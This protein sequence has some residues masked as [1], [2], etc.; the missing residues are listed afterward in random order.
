MG[1]GGG[2]TG[3]S[4]QNVQMINWMKSNGY[5]RGSRNIPFN[6]YA[7]TQE[8]GSELIYRTSDGAVL[9]PL[10]KGDK[11]FTN[12]MSERLWELAKGDFA[13]IQPNL[14]PGSVTPAKSEVN[15]NVTIQFG[16]INLPNVTNY[17]EFRSGLIKDGKFQKAVQSMTLGN[18]LGKNSLNKLRNL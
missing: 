14:I 17:E 9:T 3:S 18:A 1:F 8:K 6:Q 13:P 5:Y 16:D 12:E 2:Y 10:G 7:W 15:N 11:V 4:S